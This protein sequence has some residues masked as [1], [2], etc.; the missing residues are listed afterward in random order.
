MSRLP[1]SCEAWSAVAR[2][3]LLLGARVTS[4][5]H[6]GSL[7]DGRVRRVRAEL[8]RRCGCRGG[9]MCDAEVER[10]DGGEGWRRGRWRRLTRH[11]WRVEG[12]EARGWFCDRRVVWCL[13]GVEGVEQQHSNR[14]QKGGVAV[15]RALQ[16]SKNDAG[17]GA[18]EWAWAWLQQ[19]GDSQSNKL[20]I[21][22]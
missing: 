4:E 12:E 6:C 22:A 16:K 13:R 11:T 19:S 21:R 14:G 3:R 7:Q 15:A 20:R 18:D 1:T 8:R 5:S 17:R 2:K 10:C 9:C